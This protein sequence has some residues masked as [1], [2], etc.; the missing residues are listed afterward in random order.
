MTLPNYLGYY[1]SSKKFGKRIHYDEESCF[2]D[3]DVGMRM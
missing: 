3:T 2:E 1:A